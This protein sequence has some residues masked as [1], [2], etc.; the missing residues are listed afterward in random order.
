MIKSLSP[1]YLTIPWIAPIS[2]EICTSYTLQIFVWNGAKNTPPELPSYEIT[3]DNVTGSNAS[4]K[5]NIS[6]LVN[7]FID[8]TPFDTTSTELIDDFNQY[9]V[10][11]QILYKTYRLVDFV[12]NYENTQLMLSGYGYGMDGENPQPLANKIL[13]SGSEF[14]VSRNGYFIF[15]F[16]IEESEIPLPSFVLNSVTDEGADLFNYNATLIS[17]SGNLSLFYRQ[18]G[19]TDWITSKRYYDYSDGTY[20]FI[21]LPIELTGN[22]EFCIGLFYPLIGEHIYS[23]IITLTI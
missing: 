17:F 1:Y 15:P 23:N 8:F 5:I 6:P 22:V 4:D 9:W 14:K 7:D 10:K 12:P 2:E 20:D 13:L 16:L 21:S 18:Q 3:K 11:T 19:D